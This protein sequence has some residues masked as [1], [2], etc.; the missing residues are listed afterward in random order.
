MYAGW[1]GL[2]AGEV[3][4]E[5]LRVNERDRQEHLDNPQVQKS[6]P[7]NNNRSY[8]VGIVLVVAYASIRRLNSLASG[9]LEATDESS[10]RCP[11]VLLATFVRKLS[12]R[13]LASSSNHLV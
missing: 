11:F 1:F 10:G 12:S 13:C 2:Q 9:A 6:R 8:Y 5:R 7:E 4:K 3:G